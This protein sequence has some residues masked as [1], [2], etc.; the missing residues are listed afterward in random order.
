MNLGRFAGKIGKLQT[1]NPEA[2]ELWVFLDSVDSGLI[3]DSLD[4]LKNLFSLIL[5]NSGDTEI[6]IVTAA[7]S[8]ELA[9]NE[10]C[11]DVCQCKYVNFESY[12]DYRN[13][14]LNSRATKDKRQS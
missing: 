12:E 1:N 11:F 2:K 8:Y 10:A 14:I 13:F 7:N 4:E 6:Y 9:R 3:I 5:E